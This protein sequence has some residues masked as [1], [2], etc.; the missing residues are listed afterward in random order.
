LLIT[1]ED[2]RM[3]GGNCMRHCKK[4]R[5]FSPYDAL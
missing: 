1:P 4:R 3:R 5:A 2:A